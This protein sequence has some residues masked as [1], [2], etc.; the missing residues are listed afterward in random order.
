MALTIRRRLRVG[1]ATAFRDHITTGGDVFHR[2]AHRCGG[3]PISRRCADEG[4]G[5]MTATTIAAQGS[6]PRPGGVSI[7][8]ARPIGSSPQW[9]RAMPPALMFASRSLRRTRS[10]SHATRSSGRGL[11]STSTT[12]V[13]APSNPKSLRTPDRCRVRRSIGLSCSPTTS[14]PMNASSPVRTRTWCMAAAHWASSNRPS[15]FRC[16]TSAIAF[17]YIRRWTCGPTALPVSAKCTG[18]LRVLPP[19][20]AELAGRRTGRHHAGLPIVHQHRL[21][22][23]T[24]LHGRYR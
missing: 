16:P 8:S 22:R 18:P 9:Q 11:W 6:V 5:T 24:H 3:C 4:G 20:R 23:A 14:P 1:G 7:V 19:C 21:H 13:S 12:N 10:M 2:S 17:G 15:S